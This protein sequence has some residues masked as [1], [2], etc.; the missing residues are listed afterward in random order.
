MSLQRSVSAVLERS[1]ARH[2]GLAVGVSAAG[3]SGIWSRGV[4]PGAV[5]E[6][7]SISKT[8]T[9]TLLAGMVRD[10]LVALDDPVARHLPV[11]P[12]VKGREITLE[13]LATHHS[14]LPRQPAGMI[15]PAFTTERHDPYARFDDARLRRAIAETAPKRAPGVKFVY[16]NYAVGLL[17]YALAQRA[18]M[19]YGQLLRERITGP[20][21]LRATGLDTGPLTPGHSAFG[22]AAHPWDL[23]ELAGAGGIRSTAADMLVYLGAH[24]RGELPYADTHARRAKVGKKV[25]IGLG[26]II[27]PDGTLMHDGGTGGY[28]SFAAVSTQ[29]GVAVVVLAGTARSVNRLGMHVLQAVTLNCSASSRSSAA[30]S[31]GGANR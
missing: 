18:G 7:G 21:G 28:R 19:S 4:A 31:S 15:V 12:P 11:A 2:A 25:G 17:G 24:A 27:L 8:F 16:S 1:A 26:W 6:I 22:R 20:L 29:T 3:E 14:G 13:D 10:G 30:T 23:A 5:F 9:A